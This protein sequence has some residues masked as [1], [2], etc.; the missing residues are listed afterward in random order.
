[1]HYTLDEALAMFKP[2]N[3]QARPSYE[4]SKIRIELI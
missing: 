3:K 4:R 1:V 2:I